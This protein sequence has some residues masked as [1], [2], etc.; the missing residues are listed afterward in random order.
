MDQ[1]MEM[2]EKLALLVTTP[3][4]YDEFFNKMNFMHG[5]K[6]L[7]IMIIFIEWHCILN[8]TALYHATVLTV[9]W[10]Q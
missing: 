7:K 6:A 3:D 10:R 2:F 4:C 9:F 8:Y 1:A 5:K